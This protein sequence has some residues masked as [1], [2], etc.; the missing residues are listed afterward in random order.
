MEQRGWIALG[1]ASALG[2]G[3]LAGAA[4]SAATAMPLVDSSE[5]VSIAP[6]T[7]APADGRG[8]PNGGNRT[9]SASPS[10]A[11]SSSPG[12]SSS[13]TPSPTTTQAPAPQPVPVAPAPQ[14]TSVQSVDDDGD[15]SS[16]DG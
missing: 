4:V 10:A 2:L 3:V 1:A 15:D 7:N 5:S 12:P 16:D 14:P 11:P 8:T 13:P 9:P 6:I